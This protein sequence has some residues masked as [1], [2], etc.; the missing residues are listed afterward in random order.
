MALCEYPR[1]NITQELQRK[2]PDNHRL[3]ALSLDLCN[4]ATAAIWEKQIFDAAAPLRRAYWQRVIAQ[5]RA[6]AAA[7]PL[8]AAQHLRVYRARLVRRGTS[9]EDAEQLAYAVFT[10]ARRGL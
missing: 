6:E 2:L 3:R 1:T 5:G 4:D 8:A 10:V 9:P 7:N